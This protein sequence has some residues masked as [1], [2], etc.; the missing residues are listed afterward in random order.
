M[1]AL[2]YSLD[3]PV[4]KIGKNGFATTAGWL[5]TYNSDTRSLEY[6]GARQDYLPVGVGL[7]AGAYADAPTL[8]TEQNKAVRRKQ[9]GSGWEIVD[10]FREKLAYSTETGQSTMIDYI[11]PLADGW[12]LTPPKTSFDK[13]DGSQWVTDTDAQHAAAVAAAQSELDTRTRE[14]ETV[15]QKLALAVKYDMATDE[16]K[17]RLEAWEKYLVLLSRV[18]PA[19]APDINW[20]PVPDYVG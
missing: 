20:P 17:A 1:T 13:W 8:P 14:A 18:N 5:T 10:D 6:T 16:E 9:D 12:T 15:I 2:K 19:D 4:A 7:A 11:G 3:A